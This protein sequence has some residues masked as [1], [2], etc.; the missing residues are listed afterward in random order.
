VLSILFHYRHHD[1]SILFAGKGSSEQPAAQKNAVYYLNYYD[2][3]MLRKFR[4]HTDHVS[5]LSMC[6]AEDMFLT[7]SRDRT[8]RYVTNESSK[9]SRRF[10]GR[11]INAAHYSI[12]FPLL[13]TTDFG[14]CNRL[15]VWRK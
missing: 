3:K 8:V 2:N 7:A 13:A 1:H 4:G 15:D 12:Q 9:H 5:D 14:M 11:S 6:P 10:T